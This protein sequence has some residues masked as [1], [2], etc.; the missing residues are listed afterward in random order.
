MN[1]F[2]YL[3]RL[4][5]LSCSWCWVLGLFVIGGFALTLGIAFFIPRSGD[6]EVKENSFTCFKNQKAVLF[7]HSSKALPSISLPFQ[8]VQIRDDLVFTDIFIK[9]TRWKMAAFRVLSVGELMAE[10]SMKGAKLF[11]L[12]AIVQDL[13]GA[14]YLVVGDKEKQI[15]LSSMNYLAQCSIGDHK[16]WVKA[17]IPNLENDQDPLSLCIEVYPN[18]P[19]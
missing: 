1:I 4:W 15:S 8:S 5:R 7:F 16:K 6:N 14:E 13:E 18:I 9:E 10:L 2:K 3:Q 19:K 17:I 11:P 12:V